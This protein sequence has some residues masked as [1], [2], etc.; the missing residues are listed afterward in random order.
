MID[1]DKTM[2]SARLMRLAEI[3]GEV[4]SRERRAAYWGI[5]K[6]LSREEFT[7]AAD[8]LE[9]TEKWFPKPASFIHAARTVGWI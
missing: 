9:Q 6:K 5:L 8:H 2:F 7:R 3:H 4:V 1:D